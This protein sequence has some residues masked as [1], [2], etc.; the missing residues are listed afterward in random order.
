LPIGDI[1]STTIPPWNN[2]VLMNPLTPNSTMLATTGGHWLAFFSEL[3]VP[4]IHAILKVLTL[5]I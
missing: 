4:Y 3:A 1:V 2:M 5:G